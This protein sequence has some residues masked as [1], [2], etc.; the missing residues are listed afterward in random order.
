MINATN[1]DDE[2]ADN[3]RMYAHCGGTGGL[4]SEPNTRRLELGMSNETF[5]N[6]RAESYAT[7][8]YLNIHWTLDENHG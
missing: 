7:V 6:W 3:A 5:V 1:N 2:R 8:E 4:L